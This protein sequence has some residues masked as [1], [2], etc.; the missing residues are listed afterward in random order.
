[1]TDNLSIR[2]PVP[3]PLGHD[4]NQTSVVQLTWCKGDPGDDSQVMWM[5]LLLLGILHTDQQALDD[6]KFGVTVAVVR[7]IRHW[8]HYVLPK[9]AFIQQ[10]LQE[11]DKWN[12][13]A[14]KTK[15]VLFFFFFFL[16]LSICTHI[17]HC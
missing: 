8:K 16:S 11:E 3:Y 14:N 17:M 12:N 2:S 5:L 9:D 10:N 7:C 6:V 1:M 13:T 4:T 15:S